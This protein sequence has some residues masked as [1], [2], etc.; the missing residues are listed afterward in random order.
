MRDLATVQRYEWNY[1][2]T[3]ARASQAARNIALSGTPSFFTEADTAPL[4]AASG[5][6]VGL[7]EFRVYPNPFDKRATAQLSVPKSGPV[8]LALYDLKGQLVRQLFAGMVVAGVPRTIPL[9]APGLHPGLYFVRLVTATGVI[10]QKINCT[11][12]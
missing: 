6:A 5:R 10:T 1:A 3:N 9:E 11:H 2:T 7:P 4:A 12:N 8:T